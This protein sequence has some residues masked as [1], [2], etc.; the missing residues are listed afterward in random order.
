MKTCIATEIT[1]I[2]KWKHETLKQNFDVDIRVA[3][4]PRVKLV[5]FKSGLIPRWFILLAVQRRCSVLLTFCCFVV[6]FTRRFVLN[7]V[8]FC[9]CVF[10]SF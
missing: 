6:H 7:L 2:S 5:N 3:S 8:L 9:S 4:G 10:Q 1:Y